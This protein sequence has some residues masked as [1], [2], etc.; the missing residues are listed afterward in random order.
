[1]VSE[2]GQHLFGII[3]ALNLNMEHLQPLFIP[4][5]QLPLERVARFIFRI[6]VCH[7][8]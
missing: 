3:Y 7:G 5:K 6:Y 4:Q 8:Y 2:P 1:M